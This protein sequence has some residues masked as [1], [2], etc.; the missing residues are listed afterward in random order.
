MIGMHVL[1]Y[2]PAY[3]MQ[4]RVIN[5]KVALIFLFWVL[6]S[7]GPKHVKEKMKLI[8]DDLTLHGI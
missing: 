6:K 3:I 7:E 2:K 4:V 8:H 1:C 5:W